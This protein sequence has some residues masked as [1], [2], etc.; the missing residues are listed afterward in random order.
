MGLLV[1]NV[2]C[3]QIWK[4]Y[5]HWSLRSVSGLPSGIFGRFMSR[6]Q[7]NEFLRN[8][9]FCDNEVRETTSDKVWKV[10]KVIQ[11]LQKTFLRAWTMTSRFSIDEGVLLSSSRWNPA[12]TYVLDKPHQWVRRRSWRVMQTALT[13][14]GASSEVLFLNLQDMKSTGCGLTLVYVCCRF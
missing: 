4:L 14:T 6:N 5:H 10:R 2:L 1:A 7:F 13:A 8:L 3:P 12:Q 9:R 11:V